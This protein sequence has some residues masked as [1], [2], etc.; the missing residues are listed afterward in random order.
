[1]NRI[2]GITIGGKSFYFNMNKAKTGVSY[3]TVVAKK[4]QTEEKLTLFDSQIPSF[5]HK[6]MEAYAEI[7]EANGVPLFSAVRS[8]QVAGVDPVVAT[9]KPKTVHC[10]K[11]GVRQYDPGAEGRRR[12]GDGLRIESAEHAG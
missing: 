5:I 8:A 1:M 10:P 3:L 4:D 6:M 9:E 11:C 12:R 2:K 7:C